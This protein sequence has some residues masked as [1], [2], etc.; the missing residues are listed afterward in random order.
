MAVLIQS[1][2]ILQDMPTQQEQ[3]SEKHRLMEDIKVA[4]S[5]ILAVHNDEFEAVLRGE[6]SNGDSNES[7]LKEMRWQKDVLIQE[8]RKHLADHGC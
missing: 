4:I 6:Y 2:S 1:S 7:R 5:A 3:C 8:L